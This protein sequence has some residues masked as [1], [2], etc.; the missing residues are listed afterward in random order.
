MQISLYEKTSPVIAKHYDPKRPRELLLHKK[1]ITKIVAQTTKTGLTILLL[2]IHIAKNH[3]IKATIGIAK[4]RR[5]VDKKQLLKEKDTKRQMD[6][7]IK[8]M[9]L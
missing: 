1:E 3:R 8:N 4:I 6:K 5:K 2:D 9:R 7:D